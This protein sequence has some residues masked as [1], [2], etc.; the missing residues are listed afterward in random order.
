MSMHVF[1]ME[2][3]LHDAKAS[4]QVA[5]TDIEHLF[6]IAAQVTGACL[7]AA[8]FGNIAQMINKGDAVAVRYQALYDKIT[9]FNRFH[10]LPRRLR[11]KL[12]SYNDLLFAINRGFDMHQIASIFPINLQVRACEHR[13]LILVSCWHA[14]RCLP[15]TNT[16]LIPVPCCLC[17]GGH[18]LLAPRAFA[19]QGS[20]LRWVRRRVCAGARQAAPGGGFARG[21]LR[22]PDER[23][24][25]VDV[26]LA[27]RL[28]ANRKCRFLG[29]TADL[30][31][32][33]G[34][35]LCGRQQHKLEI[36][37]QSAMLHGWC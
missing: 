20:H 9:E 19:A 3:S 8:I 4:A 1:E 36:L 31:P 35:E 7:A 23:D 24:G 6:A 28:H 30:N 37:E 32:V 29:R 10:K 14:P 34:R 33:G 26:L 22:V 2:S 11:A 15:T 16:L 17:S 27:N 13:P 18:F 12:H 25:Q 21:R 5:I